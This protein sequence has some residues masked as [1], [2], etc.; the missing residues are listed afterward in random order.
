M[1]S[2]YF[3]FMP[4]IFALTGACG[5]L[6]GVADAALKGAPPTTT[7]VLH[8]YSSSVPDEDRS[9]YVA[10][11]KAL[12]TG[13]YGGDRVLLAPI[14][15]QT[16]RDFRPSLDLQVERTDVRLDQEE[17]VAKAEA[18]LERRAELLF[19]KGGDAGHSRI[20]EAIAAASE[21]FRA[22]EPSKRRLI[23]LTDGVEDS[24]VVNLDQPDV[25]AEEIE[26]ALI[27]AQALELLP[28]L[29]GV[30]LIIVGAGGKDFPGVRAFWIAFAR[31]TRANL[32]SYGRLPLQPTT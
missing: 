30:E 27:K 10:S 22:D 17:A 14:G 19:A 2:A 26:D 9:L 25:T 1:R 5:D 11:L 13:I 32:A 29:A 24:E 21:A 3:A 16:R 7:V 15:D 8:D 23:L 20:L 6:S 28:D 4:A 18:T 12:G 31:A